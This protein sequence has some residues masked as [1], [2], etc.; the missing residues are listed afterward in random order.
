MAKR[1]EIRVRGAEDILLASPK[2]TMGMR[3]VDGKL[4]A[5]GGKQLKLKAA[6][7]AEVAEAVAA[8]RPP[9]YERDAYAE[10]LRARYGSAERAWEMEDESAAFAMRR[11][12]RVLDAGTGGITVWI[13]R[14]D[15]A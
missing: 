2:G 15:L 12:P 5:K 3:F 9:R 6:P 11:E 10:S 1:T 13:G 14:E 7:L 8:Y 4:Y